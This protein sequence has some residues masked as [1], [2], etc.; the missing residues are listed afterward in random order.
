MISAQA[1]LASLEAF[2]GDPRRAAAELRELLETL[3]RGD[4]P[5][6]LGMGAILG[7]M[8][9]FCSIG[10]PDLVARADGQRGSVPGLGWGV[11]GGYV[12]WLDRAVTEARVALGDQR[13]ESLAREGSTLSVETLVDEMIANLNE[14]LA[15][16]R[17]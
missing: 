8:S 15:D 14:F 3:K 5:P 10:R 12:G 6:S 4:D 16:A 9:V 7:A 2:H 17:G 13:Y 11:Y 1:A